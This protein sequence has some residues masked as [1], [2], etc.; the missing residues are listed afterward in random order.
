MLVSA[1]LSIS[2]CDAYMHSNELLPEHLSDRN[3]AFVHGKKVVFE[4]IINKQRPLNSER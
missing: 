4:S 2:L 1:Q 3:L